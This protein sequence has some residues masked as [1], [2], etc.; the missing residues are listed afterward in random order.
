MTGCSRKLFL[1][2]NLVVHVAEDLPQTV[3]LLLS[4]KQ[5]L[6]REMGL[7]PVARHVP[8]E[9]EV[10]IAM[11][12]ITWKLLELSVSVNGTKCGSAAS[13]L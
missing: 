5:V 4:H 12:R 11:S 13:F 9:N 8:F 7:L 3:F 6:A 10:A 2:R 1:H